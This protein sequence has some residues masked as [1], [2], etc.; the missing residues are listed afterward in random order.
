MFGNKLWKMYDAFCRWRGVTILG[1]RVQSVPLLMMCCELILRRRARFAKILSV[2][3]ICRTLYICVLHFPCQSLSSSYRPLMPATFP[4]FPAYILRV[5]WN[6]FPI[7]SRVLPRLP[8]SFACQLQSS[9]FENINIPSPF[10]L[11]IS[12]V[13]NDSSFFVWKMTRSCPEYTIYQ[14]YI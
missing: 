5:I 1:L 7:H 13:L 14:T 2:S 4:L 3:P 12:L 9:W 10:W 8:S 11:Q 6:T